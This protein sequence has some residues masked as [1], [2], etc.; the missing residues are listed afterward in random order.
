MLKA[1]WAI[2]IINAYFGHWVKSFIE[3]L[4]GFLYF[5]TQT[6]IIRVFHLYHNKPPHVTIV[7]SKGS[8]QTALVWSEPTLV[9][10]WWSDGAMVLGK[11]Q[12][13]GRPTI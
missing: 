12:V 13:P 7:I 3:C 6:A 2:L 9:T 5:W 11:L 10:S 8:D 4:N 1:E